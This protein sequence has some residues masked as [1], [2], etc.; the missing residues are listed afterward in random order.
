MGGGGGS[1]SDGGAGAGAD[2]EVL[3][4]CSKLVTSVPLNLDPENAAKGMFD[5]D[6]TTE[7]MNSLDTVLSQELLKFNKL[8]TALRSTLNNLQRA[9]QGLAVMSVELESMYVS[10]LQGTVPNLWTNVAY[11]SLKPLASW[12][13]DLTTRVAFIK[14]WLEIGQPKIFNLPAFYFPQGF[15]TAVLQLH[16]RKYKLAINTLK[17]SFQVLSEENQMKC[18]RWVRPT[19]GN[20]KMLEG[21]GGG[22]EKEAKK[23]ETGETGETEHKTENVTMKIVDD[24]NISEFD[25]G[26]LCSGMFLEGARVALSDET[27]VLQLDDQLPRQLVS[28]LPVIHFLPEPNHVLSPG[29][30]VC[31]VYKVSTRQGVLSTT[32]MSTN[33]VVAIELP[34]GAHTSSYWVLRGTAAL[35]NLDV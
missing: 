15:M 8:L 14:S 31:P 6:P 13:A 29:S 9:I 5:V 7:L 24:N 27:N 22:E 2:V 12:V 35:L 19:G 16:A 32:G 1:G 30:Y 23:G 25:D 20:K 11:P 28:A 3:E 34:R 17:F 4:T 21:G 26:V 33:F 18:E 10:F